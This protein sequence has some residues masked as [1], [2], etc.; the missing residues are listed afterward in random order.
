[1]HLSRS[2]MIAHTTQIHPTSP[3]ILTFSDFLYKPY[4]PSLPH[5]THAFFMADNPN[6]VLD[7]KPVK[8]AMPFVLSIIPHFNEKL[9]RVIHG[10]SK[11]YCSS[12]IPT[13][14]FMPPPPT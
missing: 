13:D 7:I 14:G 12:L 5:H 9:S 4:I 6:G 10:C 2:F 8:L 11:S 3:P 1:M